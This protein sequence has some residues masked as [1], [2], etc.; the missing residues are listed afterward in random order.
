MT[1]AKLE[2]IAAEA[3]VR[4]YREYPLLTDPEF[5]ALAREKDALDTVKKVTEER[6]KAVNKDLEAYL[7]GAEAEK[8]NLWDGLKLKIGHGATA[9]KIS[10]TRLLELGVA[11]ETIL[12]ATEGGTP[13]TF[14]QIERPKSK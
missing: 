7:T 14:A 12:A 13:Y 6:L 2:K 3:A 11:L 10:A 8:V 9:S 1:K 5:E 4:D